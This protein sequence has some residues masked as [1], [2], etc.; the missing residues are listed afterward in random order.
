MLVLHKDS[1]EGV[2]LL[3]HFA[4]VP[5]HY[6]RTTPGCRLVD[7]LA[8]VR[9]KD[10]ASIIDKI[11]LMDLKRPINYYAYSKKSFKLVIAVPNAVVHFLGRKANVHDVHV[12]LALQK[13]S[14]FVFH[15]DNV[16]LVNFTDTKAL[17]NILDLIVQ[18]QVFIPLVIS[19]ASCV[20]YFLYH[21]LT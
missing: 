12:G 20:I 17:G 21:F 2:N 11:P 16:A 13:H 1:V 7:L 14:P 4:R 5:L 6:L 19:D 18:P 3:K 15:F 10:A 9:V 8:S